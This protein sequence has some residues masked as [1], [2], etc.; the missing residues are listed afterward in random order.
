MAEAFVGRER[1]LADLAE[2]L[3]VTL[4]GNGQTCFVVGQAGSGKTALARHFIEGALA[5]DGELVVAA[6]ACNAQ[7]G[8]GDPYLPFREALTALSG[9]EQQAQGT[10]QGGP[11]NLARL[12]ALA[13]ISGRL[14]IEAAPDLV[15][16]V[17][18][19][20]GL[21]GRLGKAIA[22]SAGWTDDLKAQI[23]PGKARDAGIVEQSRIFE[24]Y[25]AFLR[26]LSARHPPPVPRRSAV[27]RWAVDRPPLPP[28]PQP[29]RLPRDAPRRVP[30]ER[31]R[32]GPR[33]G[34]PPPGS[35]RAR[36]DPLRRRRHRRPR[37]APR[38]G[39]PR[40]YRC[41]GGSR[42]E[43]PGP[44]FPRGGVPQDGGAGALCR[45]TAPRPPRARRLGAR[46][47]RR[48]GHGGARRLGGPAGARRG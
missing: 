6:G 3:D 44:G 7:T 47:R 42:A 29:G 17:I 22:V 31:R 15:G 34:P 40:L 5:A 28:G 27:G 43:P 20:A 11:V 16:L 10:Q 38:G 2:R 46:C 25:E 13:A 32:H 33:R 26:R 21:A 8:I 9:E 4:R 41:A 24:Q 1:E 18:P 19:G 12:R 36:D 35:G 45:R 14:L 37:R 30:G 23:R 39:H 48:L